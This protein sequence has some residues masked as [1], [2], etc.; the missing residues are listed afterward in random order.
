MK[1]VYYL[2]LAIIVFLFFQS[3]S[4]DDLTSEKNLPQEEELSFEEEYFL[5]VAM[6]KEFGD[7]VF[8]IKK[9]NTDLLI[10]LND[11]LNSEL[12]DE[13]ELVK[14]EIN[15]LSSSIQLKRVYEE[16]QANFV[17]FFSDKDTYGNY[18]PNAVDFLDDNWGLTWIYWDSDCSIYKGS[19][20]VD[21]VRNN[22]LN[23]IKH[24]L[25]EEFTQGLGLLND[26]FEY[27]QSIF[28][29]EWTC[30][31]FYTELDKQVIEFFLNPLIESGMNRN[32]VLEILG[33]L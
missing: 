32:Q 25:R 14:D 31:T 24:L 27:P 33:Q 29:Q 12:V 30:T 11:T 16:S 13:F 4:E 8:R 18:E 20:Y 3:C 15:E 21:T 5:E 26:S 7:N 2:L 28:Y 6:E 22:D 19:L 17:I 10:Y 23:C 9:W 1:S